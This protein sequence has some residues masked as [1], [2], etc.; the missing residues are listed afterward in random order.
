MWGM[1]AEC[2]ACDVGRS[3]RGVHLLGWDAV[4]SQPTLQFV[5]PTPLLPHPSPPLPRHQESLTSTAF[6]PTADPS[7]SP[8]C[9]PTFPEMWQVGGREEI[10]TLLWSRPRGCPAGGVGARAHAAAAAAAAS[11]RYSCC[12]FKWCLC[13]PALPPCVPPQQAGRRLVS[14]LHPR[15]LLQYPHTHTVSLLPVFHTQVARCWST[16]ST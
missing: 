14:V 1:V 8:S 2:Q 3:R 10:Q 4:A 13:P 9:G 11:S 7:A 12:L 16:T 6:A 5:P 15:S